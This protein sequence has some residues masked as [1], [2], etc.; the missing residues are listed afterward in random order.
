DLDGLAGSRVA[1]IPLGPAAHQE[2]AEAADGDLP[3]AAERFE[4][5]AEQG[6]E[7]LL[8][9]DLRAAR[10]LGH[11]RHEVRLDHGTPYYAT[12]PAEVKPDG[13][14]DVYYRLRRRAIGRDRA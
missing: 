8:G 5:V 11:R 10:G 4:H 1:A 14:P 6:I 3:S 13:M 2:G 7:R 9:R 12:A